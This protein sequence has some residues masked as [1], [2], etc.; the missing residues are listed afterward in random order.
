VRKLKLYKFDRE[1]RNGEAD[2]GLAQE[3][4][5]LVPYIGGPEAPNSSQEPTP[6]D[7]EPVTVEE[8]K[9]EVA[10]ALRE[11]WQLPEEERRS[12]VRR[13]IRQ[14]HPDRNPNRVALATEV[15]QYLLNEVE[16][17]ERGGVPGYQPDADN[18]NQPPRRPPGG[19]RDY[20]ERQGERARRQRQQ[21][22]ERRFYEDD[23]EPANRN[24]G[25]R[26][27][28]QAEKDFDTA[29]YLSRSEE[30][31]YYAYTCFHCQQAVE[32]AL[33]AFMFAK[34]RLQRN[35][36]QVHDVLALAYRASTMDPRL[37]GVPDMVRFIH[38]YYIKTR[39]P[40]YRRGISLGGAIPAE[41]FTQRQAN[42]AL[43][44]A[45]TILQLVREA[46]D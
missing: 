19:Y 12:C 9:R 33:K 16:R 36:L 18:A 35:D 20:A 42:E 2:A 30:E 14:W 29:N 22:E 5:D 34:G 3:I 40:L 31:T 43:S 32:K 39:Y 28:R 23:T 24:E 38:E 10:E 46:M 1:Q 15:T 21:R 6:P 11:I 41:I 37:R 45:R 27:T 17:L 4:L 26:W 8:A 25:E 7:S 44:N 13:L